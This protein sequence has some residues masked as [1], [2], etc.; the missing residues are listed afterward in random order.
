MGMSGA[1]V[2]GEVVWKGELL[3][4][5]GDNVAAR[6][7]ANGFVEVGWGTSAAGGLGAECVDNPVGCPASME[8]RKGFVACAGGCKFGIDAPV[9]NEAT[10]S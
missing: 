5:G 7:R 2:G 6:S 10:E 4:A 9:W 3:A 8:V 1:A